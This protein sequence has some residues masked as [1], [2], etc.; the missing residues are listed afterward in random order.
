MSFKT[1]MTF[2]TGLFLDSKMAS[3]ALSADF[4]VTFT[5]EAHVA[6][7]ATVNACK[8]LIFAV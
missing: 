1:L 7:A 8:D 3:S 2:A 4:T 5:P 6:T